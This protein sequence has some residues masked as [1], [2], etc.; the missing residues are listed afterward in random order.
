MRLSDIWHSLYFEVSHSSFGVTRKRECVF[1]C[2][3]DTRCELLHLC[4]SNL[5]NE[6]AVCSPLFLKEYVIG[7]I[8]Q[9]SKKRTRIYIIKA[10]RSIERALTPLCQC[11][12]WMRKTLLPVW[13]LWDDILKIQYSVHLMKYVLPRLP[14]LLPVGGTSRV[15]Y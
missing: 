6:A 1:V 10:A 13:S 2:E 14:F 4:S 7:Q 12:A 8:Q 3:G 11:A 5:L 9:V 15:R